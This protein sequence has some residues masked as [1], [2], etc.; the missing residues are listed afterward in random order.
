MSDSATYPVRNMNGGAEST[1]HAYD[2]LRGYIL[3][4]RLEPGAAFSQVQ[5]SQQL[6]VSRTPLREAV[7]LLQMEGLVHSEYN[8]RVTVAPLSASACEELYAMRIPLESLAVRLSVPLLTDAELDGAEQALEELDEAFARGDHVAV[9]EPHRRF[10]FTLFGHGG[11]LMV[12]RVADL[13]DHAQ[14]FRLLYSRE[15]GEEDA[16]QQQTAS[17]HAAMLAAARAR[18]EALTMRLVADHLGR[19]VLTTLA[20]VDNRYDPRAVRAALLMVNAQTME[21]SR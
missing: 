11:D 14:R 1:K 9:R 15:A 19:I 2:Q 12:A 7:R 13:W 18:D 21:R 17:E 8:R 6:G 16:L 5:L 4:G 3:E 20:R 10:H